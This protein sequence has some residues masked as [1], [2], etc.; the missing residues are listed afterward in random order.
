MTS[1][2]LARKLQQE[3][4]Q[5]TVE[6]KR[7]VQERDQDRHVLQETKLRQQ[8]QVHEE[9]P[10]EP[11]PPLKSSHD[12]L[13]ELATAGEAVSFGSY[14]TPNSEQDAPTTDGSEPAAP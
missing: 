11:S 6:L 12:I 13:A 5:L 9:V 7:T 1:D 10:D 14:R 4:I 2:L 8:R 3:L